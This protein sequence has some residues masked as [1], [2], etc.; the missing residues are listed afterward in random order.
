MT[1]DNDAFEYGGY[2]FKP[3]H[4]FS[5]SEVDRPLEGDSRPW[6]RDVQHAMRNMRTD[7]L[8]AIRNYNNGKVAW[9][10]EAFYAASG[11]SDADIFMCV[12]NGKMYVPGENELFR[13]ELRKR[14]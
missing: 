9:S 10:H 5:K 11:D 2:H 1:N 14:N 13:Y 8:L 12:E 3:Y 6:K 4:K 7:N